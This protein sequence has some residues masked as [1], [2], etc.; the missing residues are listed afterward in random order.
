MSIWGSHAFTIAMVVENK[1]RNKAKNI[2]YVFKSLYF[3]DRMF[4]FSFD[5]NV[6]QSTTPTLATSQRAPCMWVLF[7]F[8]FCEFCFVKKYITVLPFI[9]V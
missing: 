2:L 8:C 5:C 4:M 9:F 6:M 7:R 1:S 3:N